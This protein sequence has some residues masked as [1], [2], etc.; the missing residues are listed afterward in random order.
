M[1]TGLKMVVL[2]SARQP[3]SRSLDVAAGRGPCNVFPVA[4]RALGKSPDPN[5][6]QLASRKGGSHD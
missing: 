6:F 5:L 3:Q 2:P 4:Y 1:V